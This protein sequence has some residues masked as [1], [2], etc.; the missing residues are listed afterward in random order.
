MTLESGNFLFQLDPSYATNQ[1]GKALGSLRVA[2]SPRIIRNINEKTDISAI[3]VQNIH[4]RRVEAS[5]DTQNE[6][7]EKL[8]K[9]FEFFLQGYKAKKIKKQFFYESNPEV[10]ACHLH[11]LMKLAAATQIEWVEYLDFLYSNDRL[12]YFGLLKHALFTNNRDLIDLFTCRVSLD[13]LSKYFKKKGDIYL[14]LKD[15]IH[16]VEK[17]FLNFIPCF[18]NLFQSSSNHQI[19]LN[20]IS[21]KI[22]YCLLDL[23]IFNKPFIID[24]QNYDEAVTIAYEL[25]VPV[26]KEA[27]NRW[28]NENF[29]SLK[30][31]LL[32]LISQRYQMSSLCEKALEKMFSIKQKQK[33]AKE[34]TTKNKK[35]FY[36][37]I[38]FYFKNCDLKIT[39]KFA[40]ESNFEKFILRLSDVKLVI[41]EEELSA[42]K[43]FLSWV[44]DFFSRMFSTGMK[45]ADSHKIFLDLPHSE[46][47]ISFYNYLLKDLP[48]VIDGENIL[49]FLE[50]GRYLGSKLLLQICEDWLEGNIPLLD[51][52]ELFQLAHEY[53]LLK[54]QL[55]LVLKF[56]PNQNFPTLQILFKKFNFLSLILQEND[57]LKLITYYENIHHEFREKKESFAE[58]NWLQFLLRGNPKNFSRLF[59]YYLDKRDRHQTKLFLKLLEPEEI[60]DLLVDKG[61]MSIQ[62]KD[63]N[64]FFHTSLLN[65]LFPDY[66][67]R[68][69]SHDLNTMPI[70]RD[71]LVLLMKL[72]LDREEITASNLIKVL[73]ILNKMALP[74][75][76]KKVIRWMDSY[77]ID[78]VETCEAK[79]KKAQDLLRIVNECVNHSQLRKITANFEKTLFS[80]LTEVTPSSFNLA[81][82][83]KEQIVEW[84]N[85]RDKLNLDIDLVRNSYVLPF[86]H[87]KSLKGIKMVFDKE[88]EDNKILIAA[89]CLTTLLKDLKFNLD[90]HITI[91]SKQVFEHRPLSNPFIEEMSQWAISSLNLKN[92]PINDSLFK[93]LNLPKLRKLNLENCN[94]LGKE[95]FSHI[96]SFSELQVLNLSNTKMDSTRLGKLRRLPLRK[97]NLSNCLEVTTKRLRSK[98][99]V[100]LKRFNQ[101]KE[102]KL[103]HLTLDQEVVESLSKLTLDFLDLEHCK[104]LTNQGIL[105]LHKS[106]TIKKVN[107]Q[108]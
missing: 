48:L 6:E 60:L 35:I 63:Q 56:F 62:L 65:D 40:I 86:D 94:Q 22:F 67:P 81:R 45:E 79:E 18:E 76:N 83:T 74:I 100:E 91:C 103:C 9:K 78:E 20:Q 106:Q 38:F 57:V 29:A 13:D 89:S 46:L 47:F 32:F 52:P 24:E 10:K 58:I 21:S 51:Q 5:S 41:D 54:L 87:R 4:K 26:L 30:P 105:K 16:V 90:I 77:K 64:C 104:G 23:I 85:R 49:S 93:R 2:H 3:K 39:E 80:Y 71:D 11:K 44:S 108:N 69:N 101:L 73:G 27:C 50:L 43:L 19:N 28:I 59:V 61:N 36:D 70:S 82:T 14:I 12:I 95:G 8:K 15:E 72:R 37:F 42:N 34:S 7:G 88:N 107:M 1:S 68:F 31:W 96:K 55:Q 25:S 66:I 98:G 84:F 97:L 53:G 92:M 102:L 17:S 33:I 99:L 75:T